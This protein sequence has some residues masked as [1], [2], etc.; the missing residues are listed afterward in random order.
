VGPLEKLCH[1]TVNLEYL[2]SS[3]AVIAALLGGSV[4]YICGSYGS[5]LAA[6]QQGT[7]SNIVALTAGSQGGGSLIA[8]NIKYKS[9]GIGI[10]SLAKYATLGPWGVPS[11]TGAGVPYINEALKLD[12]VNSGNVQKVVVGTGGLA[13]LVSGK[14][15]VVASAAAS[16]EPAILDGQAFY[17]WYENG[18]QAYQLTGL[19]PSAGLMTLN[20]TIQQYK[21]LT[22]Q[23]VDVNIKNYLFLQKNTFHPQTVYNATVPAYKA[24]TPYGTF[25]AA[26]PFTRASGAPMTGLVTQSGM[27]RV[28]NIFYN[29]GVITSP[30][31]ISK[32]QVDTSFVEN[33]YTS[34]GLPAPT[35]QVN[36]KLL[37]II[38][39]KYTGLV[40]R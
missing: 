15:N 36:S 19:L 5:L 14:V 17:I 23:M 30:V 26:W 18:L 32:S 13:A 4:Q 33:A 34:M 25:A 10:K 29:N 22:Q 35:S 24:V 20:T 21:E 38:G 31:K 11:L 37:Y 2:S 3:T 7:G 40:E 16:L 1:T 12:G 8:A 28:A 27:Q 9:Y 39:D 6:L